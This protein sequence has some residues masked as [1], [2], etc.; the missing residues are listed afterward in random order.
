MHD[1][2]VGGDHLALI[3]RESIGLG[4]SVPMTTQRCAE[5]LLCLMLTQILSS[6]DERGGVWGSTRNY[7]GLYIEPYNHFSFKI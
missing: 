5:K 3:T 4:K 1:I 6:L 2:C 7:H